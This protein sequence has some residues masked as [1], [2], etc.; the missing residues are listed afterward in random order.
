MSAAE[1]PR[2]PKRG[3]PRLSEAE[4][5]DRAAQRRLYQRGY[6]IKRRAKKMRENPE[7]VLLAERARGKRSRDKRKQAT[8]LSATDA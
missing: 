7:A 5:A 6:A 4:R 2:P 8:E 3:R 1:P